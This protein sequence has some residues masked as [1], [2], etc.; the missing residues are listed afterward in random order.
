MYITIAAAAALEKCVPSR[1]PR[2][3]LKGKG[4]NYLEASHNFDFVS[5]KTT[6]VAKERVSCDVNR[7]VYVDSGGKN[8]WDANS[9]EI[10]RVIGSGE[11]QKAC[12]DKVIAKCASKLDWRFDVDQD[13]CDFRNDVGKKEE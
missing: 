3:K 13:S 5:F 4:Q 11:S 9:A 12:L 7:N 6:N 2:R 10:S 1:K 8:K